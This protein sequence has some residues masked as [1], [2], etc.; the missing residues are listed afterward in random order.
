MLIISIILW[1][2]FVI[3]LIGC[4]LATFA[5]FAEDWVYGILAAC[6]L[7]ASIGFLAGGRT[8]SLT[9]STDVCESF[10]EVNPNVE[11]HMLVQTYWSW[12]CVATTD[13]GNTVPW[14]EYRI[15]LEGSN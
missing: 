6:L 3:A 1:M 8:A 12:E 14:S 9:Y 15:I 2:L 13:E 7:V 11:I 10:D 4:C 5:A